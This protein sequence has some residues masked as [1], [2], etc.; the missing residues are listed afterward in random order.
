MTPLQLLG[1]IGVFAVARLSL[2]FASVRTAPADSTASATVR[3]YLDAFIVAGLIALFLITFVVRTF[4]IPSESM[5]PTLEQ[6]DVLLVNEFAYRLSPPHRGDIVVFR[7]PVESPSNFIKRIIAVPGDTLRIAHGTVYVNGIAQR[8]PYI[9]QKPAYAL[10]LKNYGIYVDNGDGYAAL[11][12]A[13]ANIPSRRYWQHPD[14]IPNGFYFVMGD[15]RNDSED[16]H[17]WGFAQMSGRFASGPL[18]NSAETAAFTGRAFLVL[19][20]LGRLRLLN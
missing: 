8:E 13:Q 14:R 18:S 11:D 17:I 7:P 5:V 12:P 3:E 4:Y 10:E 6:R 15:N 20:P 16:S 1:L 9:A 19:W 2:T